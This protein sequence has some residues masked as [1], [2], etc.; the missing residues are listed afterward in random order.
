MPVF[1]RERQI[2]PYRQGWNIVGVQMNCFI[3]RVFT[4]H[5]DG[6]ASFKC[7]DDLYGAVITLKRQETL[8]EQGPAFRQ[9]AKHITEISG[10]GRKHRV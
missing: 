3:F 8:T 1:L 7:Q 10:K 5:P 4:D 6:E 9:P 2:R